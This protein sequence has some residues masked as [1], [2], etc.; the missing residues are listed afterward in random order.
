M[1]GK[2]YLIGVYYPQGGGLFDA[3]FYVWQAKSDWFIVALY[4]KQRLKLREIWRLI[5]GKKYRK[6]IMRINH[7]DR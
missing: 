3:P 5:R 7:Y 4:H 1:T 2:R 6:V